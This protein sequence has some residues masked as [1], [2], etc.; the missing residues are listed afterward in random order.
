VSKSPNRF[1]VNGSA[2][3]EGVLGSPKL[4]QTVNKLGRE[5]ASEARKNAAA[6][7]DTGTSADNRVAEVY[8][9]RFLNYKGI[10]K[11]GAAPRKK[12]NLVGRWGAPSLKPYIKTGG[13]NITGL[14]V[15]NSKWSRAL[16]YGGLGFPSSF[17]LNKALRTVQSRYPKDTTI[18]RYSG[19]D[20]HGGRPA[21]GGS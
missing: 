6:F 5:I 19:E 12:K 10:Q 13:T 16:E 8:N 2:I 18:S 20:D 9:A 7:G 11:K 14:V 4:R 21:R 3:V 15:S 1:E 17:F